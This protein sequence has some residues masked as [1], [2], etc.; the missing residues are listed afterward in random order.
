MSIGAT[1]CGGRERSL[2]RH[3]RACSNGLHSPLA[4][5]GRLLALE[6]S[7][8]PFLMPVLVRV[9]PECHAHLLERYVSKTALFT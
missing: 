9:S 4:R 1:A 7:S 5:S 8:L 6:P 2:V 3:E